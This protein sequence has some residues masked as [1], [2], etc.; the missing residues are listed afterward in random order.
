MVVVPGAAAPAAWSDAPRVVVGTGALADPGPVVD[1]LHRAWLGRQP[2]VVELAVDAD[3]LRRPEVEGRPPHALGAG[4]TFARERLQFLVWANNYDARSGEPVWW[5]GR[6]AARLLADQ[7]VVEGGPADVSLADGTPCRIDGGPPH[8]P[9]PGPGVAV[10]HRWNA[11]RGRLRPAGHRAPS[12]ELADDQRAAVTHPAGPV[13]VIAPAGSGKTRVLAER[14]RH[15]VVDRGVDPAVVTVVAYNTKAAEELRARCADF[16]P[17]GTTTIR[18]LNSLGLW[19]CNRLGSTGSWT[20]V[21]EPRVRALVQQVFE[22]PRQANAD[23]VAPFIGAL[24]AVRLGLRDPREV[25]EAMPDAAG[26]GEG[27]D[28]YRRALDDAHLLDFDEQI[29]RAV[30]VLLTD[31]DARSR[32]QARCRVLLVDE[33]QDLTPAHVLLL[34]LLS[35]PGYDCFGVGDD[36]QVIYGYSGADPGFL[37]EYGRYFPGAAERALEVNYRCP[38][39]VVDAAVHLL[40][41][42]RRRVAKR[43]RAAR[44]PDPASLEVRARPAEELALEAVGLVRGW[45]DDGVPPDDIAVLA[46]VNSALLPV[47]VACAEAGLPCATPLGAA[48]LERTGVRTALAYL[49]IGLDPDRIAPADVRDTIRRPSRSVAPRVVEMLTSGRGTSLTDIRRLAGRLTGRDAPKLEAYADDIERLAGACGRSTAVALRTVR[50]D[51][52]LGGT[53]DVLDSS[54]KEPDRSTHTDDLL[55]LESVAALHPDV[56]SFEPWLRQTLGRPRAD[57]DLV[58]LSTVHRIKGREWGHVVVFG[59]SQGSFPHRLSQDEEGERRVFHVALTR[60]RHRVVILAA[61]DA[62]SIF[63]A[64]LDGSRVVPPPPPARAT[65]RTAAKAATGRAAPRGEA[66]PAEEALRAWRRSAASAQGVPAYVVLNDRE[67]VGIAERSP[68]SLADLASCPGIGSIRLERY[69]D[70][71]L[72]VLEGALGSG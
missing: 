20:V 31:P 49:R 25:E 48:V 4:F 9:D 22:V 58:L 54:R 17:E 45:L 40:S 70:E 62:P 47:Q 3:D 60:T 28:A 43:I 16:L 57:G 34:R 64:E 7:G 2:V 51:I 10:V 8:P 26:V 1:T 35:A 18:T 56:G 5:H 67:L 68:R 19:I 71:I 55:A 52:G 6:K 41:Y 72:A 13:R 27:F 24:S 30:E 50:V 21:D 11:E 37:L 38:P 63:V 12:S 42:N 44:P 65:A 46:R 59:A 14:L 36:D 33:F 29:Y 69:G 53:M 39:E 23:T 32:A 61:R 66:G 15:L